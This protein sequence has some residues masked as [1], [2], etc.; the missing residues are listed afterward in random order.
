[1]KNKKILSIILC[2]SIIFFSVFVVNVQQAKAWP[3]SIAAVNALEEAGILGVDAASLARDIA[4]YVAKMAGNI[5][6]VAVKIAALMVVQQI[7]RA[8][9]GDGGGGGTIS[10]WNNYL[11]VSPQQKAMAQMNIF[12]NSVSRGRLSSLNYEGVGPN[13]D[14]YL[15]A[16]AR[17]SIN[18]QLFITNI[19]D[20]ATDPSKMFATQNMK[21][22][23]SFV[24]PP[25]NPY[26]YSIVAT[27]QYNKEFSKAQ[28]IAK[29][30]QTN[31][32]LPI[33]KNG[34]VTQPASLAQNALLQIDQLGTNLIMDS[35]F[36]KQ[37]AGAFAQIA[38]GAGISIAARSL[39]YATA[40]S[41]GKEAI[42]NKNDEMPFSLSYSSTGGF[43]ATSGGKTASTGVGTTKQ[44]NSGVNSAVSGIGNAVSSK[45]Y[46]APDP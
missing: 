13:Y 42:R 27:E 18:G 21:G 15:V 33:K 12:F 4:E 24:Q 34:K 7:T 35:N 11:Y 22:I 5:A 40:N 36:E 31:G 25:N 9:I 28:E 20:Q 8:I 3:V 16:Q 19:Q 45:P 37:N 10:D 29:N 26:S 38:A 2:F 39:N 6:V 46:I 43:G 32:F 17:Q 44:I 1:M 23:M 14:A 30:E 41:A